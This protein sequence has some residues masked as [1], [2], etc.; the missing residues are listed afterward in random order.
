ML[1]NSTKPVLVMAVMFVALVL[2]SA[3]PA[4][5]QREFE[6]LFDK[7]SFKA[8]FSWVAVSTDIRL[9]SEQLGRGTTLSFENDLGLGKNKAVPTLDFE[10]QI[11]KRHKVAGRWQ[12]IDRGSSSQ[13]LKEIQWGDE[14]IPI[15]A[16]VD[17][18]FDINQFFVDYAFYPWVKERWAAGFG[19]GIR[20]MEIQAGLEWDLDG[21]QNQ[22][23]TDVK[24][25]GPLPY[26]YFEYRRLFTDHWRFKTGLGVF[27]LKV[28]D[29]DGSQWIA[30]VDIE[31]LIGKRWSVGGSINL[32]TINV[33]WEGLK[34]EV[35]DSLYN[36]AIDMNINDISVYGR[37][38]F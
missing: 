33:D 3:V 37:V 19:L 38:R 5:A 35:G 26:I 20:W 14:I 24:G 25:T 2:A 13:A 16:S 1:T 17:L 21:S 9:D 32:S 11:A 31:Y 6:P 28:G 4:E 10:W 30:N 27:F 34:D 12:R 15:D 22:G 7:Y 29:I 18:S 8:E 36:G 23:S